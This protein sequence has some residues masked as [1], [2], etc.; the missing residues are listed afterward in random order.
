MRTIALLVDSDCEDPGDAWVA[1]NAA[2]SLTRIVLG[3]ECRLM[4]HG[5]SGAVLAVLLAAAEY[6]KPA[7]L[8][9][10]TPHHQSIWLLRPFD[11]GEE[12]S[13]VEKHL[14]FHHQ[15]FDERSEGI[16]RS[17][18]YWSRCEPSGNGGPNIFSRL[19]PR[20][21]FDEL[22]PSVIVKLGNRERLAE[23]IQLADVYS[24][25]KGVPFYLDGPFSDDAHGN[26]LFIDSV[27]SERQKSFSW[28][29]HSRHIRELGL[30]LE[31][32]GDQNEQIRI[33]ERLAR[34]SISFEMII[35]KVRG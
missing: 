23:T 26:Q 10:E 27:L 30:H 21:A 11:S 7:A 20:D 16:V 8:K 13:S 33:S 25:E 15:G 5:D 9:S 29:A 34:L 17:L 3:R 2:I 14:L 32:T 1:M 4:V 6:H 22:R 35:D 24:R 28:I 19:E 12:G 31:L 18:A